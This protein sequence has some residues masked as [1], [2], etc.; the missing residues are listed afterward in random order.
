MNSR[1]ITKPWLN[2]HKRLKKKSNRKVV[3]LMEMAEPPVQPSA[4]MS[5]V[6]R[7]ALRGEHPQD[8][9]SEDTKTKPISLFLKE[10]N[11]L[12][13]GQTQKPTTPKT[14]PKKGTPEYRMRKYLHR[15]KLR[16]AGYNP[17]KTTVLKGVVPVATSAEQQELVIDSKFTFEYGPRFEYVS[18]G[19]S[20]A[21]LVPSPNHAIPLTR[22]QIDGAKEM[23]A[24]QISGG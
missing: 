7:G 3:I 15:K 6:T 22:E 14:P 18:V 17:R 11:D 9:S 23:V 5:R 12:L 8:G 13:L 24:R 20:E 2:P 16:K 4:I 10:W 21:G 19:L 1:K